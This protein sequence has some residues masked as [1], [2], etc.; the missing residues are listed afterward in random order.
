MAEAAPKSHPFNM[1]KHIYQQPQTINRLV[2]D[3]LPLIN[4][5]AHQIYSRG[6]SARYEKVKT[7]H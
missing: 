3:E 4:L 6:K 1:Y 2:T 7:L 5:A